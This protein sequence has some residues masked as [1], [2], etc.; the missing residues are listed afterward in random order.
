MA[1]TVATAI[2]VGMSGRKYIKDIYLSDTV[3]TPINWDGGAGA[4]ATSPLDWIPPEPVALKDLAVVTGAAQTKLQVTLNGVPTG[5]ILR[6]SMQLN[7]LANR[8]PLACI[9]GAGQRVAMLQL[10]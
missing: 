10:A 6:H 3:N 2:F 4:S 9:F 5:D 1:A 7:T 8:T